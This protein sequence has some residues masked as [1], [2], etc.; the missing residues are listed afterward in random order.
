MCVGSKQF[1][2]PTV[3]L[4]INTPVTLFQQYTVRAETDSARPQLNI[5][6]SNAPT[7]AEALPATAQRQTAACNA[8]SQSSNVPVG[9]VMEVES[10]NSNAQQQQPARAGDKTSS[11]YQ[12]DSRRGNTSVVYNVVSTDI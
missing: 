6:A 2:I 4:S 7:V 8:H 9:Y 11:S 1:D 12:M 5:D 3:Q 10:V